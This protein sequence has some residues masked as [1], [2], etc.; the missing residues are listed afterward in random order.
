MVELVAVVVAELVGEPVVGELV[1]VGR[2]E[3]EQAELVLAWLVEIERLVAELVK[4]VGLVVGFERQ[5]LVGQVAAQVQLVGLG[6]VS[7]G[8][9]AGPAELVMVEPVVEPEVPAAGLVV[10][11]GRQALVGEVEQLVELVVEREEL[12][13]VAGLVVVVAELELVVEQASRGQVELEGPDTILS[14]PGH[15]KPLSVG[16]SSIFFCQ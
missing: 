3:L 11:L 6:Q 13:V 2:V 14:G 9:V 16:R 12:A 4:A 8:R 1:L 10:R 7:A 5:V 15:K